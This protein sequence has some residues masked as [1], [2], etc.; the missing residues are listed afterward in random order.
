MHP[1]RRHLGDIGLI[2]RLS[3]IGETPER[4]VRMAYLAIVGSDAVNGVA[5][6]HTHILKTRLFAD[7]DRFFPGRILNVT[8]GIS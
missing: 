7:F 3:L 6:L 8:N 2:G 5:V 1:A 4:R